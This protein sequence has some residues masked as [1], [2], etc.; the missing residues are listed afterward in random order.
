MS[1]PTWIKWADFTGWEEA[2]SGIKRQTKKGLW[3]TIRFKSSRM[4]WECEWTHV[5]KTRSFTTIHC[6]ET[7]EHVL[8]KAT[9]LA[10]RHGGW[11]NEG[12]EA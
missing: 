5:G 10:N 6:G 8:G 2:C 7:P 4:R 1:L 11:K 3:I 12:G 9:A